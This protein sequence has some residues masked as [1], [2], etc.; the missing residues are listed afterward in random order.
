LHGAV[1]VDGLEV[2]PGNVRRRGLEV[3]DGV[4][5]EYD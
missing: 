1:G 5:H 2:V 4:E 3:E